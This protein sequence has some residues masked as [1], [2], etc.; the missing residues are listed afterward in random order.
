MD[1]M[2]MRSHLLFFFSENSRAKSCHSNRNPHEFRAIAET[3][4]FKLVTYDFC[5]S[6]ALYV[7][8][9]LEMDILC[10]QNF[11]NVTTV[12]TTIVLSSATFKISASRNLENQVGYQNDLSFPV[13]NTTWQAVHVQFVN[14]YD[15]F[16][17]TW[18]KYKWWPRTHLTCNNSPI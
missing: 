5:V 7:A 18:R 4:V 17:S 15:H 11:I 14:I 13:M 12:T 9:Q 3:F 2:K 1:V 8:W 10:V 16:D 6:N